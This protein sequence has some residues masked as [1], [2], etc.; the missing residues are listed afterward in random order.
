MTNTWERPTKPAIGDTVQDRSGHKYKVTSVS[1]RWLRVEPVEG[2]AERVLNVK[3]AVKV[4]ETAPEKRRD[5][6]SADEEFGQ[7]YKD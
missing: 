6:M 4:A 1:V 7:Y 2:G 3:D 5:E